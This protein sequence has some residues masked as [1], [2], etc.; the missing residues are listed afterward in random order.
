[1]AYVSG[2][3]GG[4]VVFAGQRGRRRLFEFGDV[5]RTEVG[6]IVTF[7][8]GPQRFHRVEFRG[9]GR[10]ELDVKIGNGRQVIVE[11]GGT[12]RAQTI[13][14]QYDGA[15]EV[16]P[17][18]FQHGDNHRVVD[19]VFRLQIVVTTQSTTLRRDGQDPDRRDPRVMHQAMSQVR[20]LSTGS[21]GLLHEWDHRKAAFVPENEGGFQSAD[22][23]LIRG[24]STWTQ[25]SIAASSRSRDRR[26]G[27]CRV[28][29]NDFKSV[30]T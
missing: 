15:A 9:V 14:Q 12:V 10:E 8:V 5:V 24:Q 21:P 23:F 30:G 13:P 27:F 25:C 1:M 3:A 29:P 19:R 18:L 20:R 26:S 28:Q 2:D 7:R 11:E 16:P 4:V 17:H 6:Q 22:F